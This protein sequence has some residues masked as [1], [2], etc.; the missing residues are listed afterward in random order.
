LH[1]TAERLY[2]DGTGVLRELSEGSSGTGQFS[3]AGAA[4]TALDFQTEQNH[5]RIGVVMLVLFVIALALCGATALA[6]RGWGRLG[7]LG[8]LLFAASSA[9]LIAGVII[10][11]Y[12][13]ATS[14][15]DPVR[16]AFLK[17][18]SDLTMI[19]IRNG[20]AG[21]VAGIAL[22]AIAFVGQALSNTESRRSAMNEGS[23]A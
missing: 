15:G 7:V 19:A 13:E 23:Q 6:C 11:L 4:K 12:A 10:F 9:V 22:C 16:E 1:R 20:V 5:Q 17:N 3:A 21:A 18:T 8:V 14:G 2:A